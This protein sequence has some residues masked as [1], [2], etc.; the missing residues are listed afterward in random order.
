MIT[1]EGL[2]AELKADAELY[3]QMTGESDEHISP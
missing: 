2:W 1:Y 3:Q